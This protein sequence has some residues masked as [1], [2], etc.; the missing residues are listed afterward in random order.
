VVVAA[1][2]KGKEKEVKENIGH[3]THT[4]S[5]IGAGWMLNSI[6]MSRLAFKENLL[7]R[8]FPDAM[9]IQSIHV[10][11]QHLCKGLIDALL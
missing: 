2:G 4:H 3:E 6:F 5:N 8:K 1:A 9:K 11:V 10:C 7:K